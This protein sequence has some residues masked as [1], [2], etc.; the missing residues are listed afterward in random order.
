MGNLSVR[1]LDEETMRLLRLRA[2]RNGRL[3]EEE[4]RRIIREAVSTPE[5]NRRR[6]GPPV[7]A[8]SRSGSRTSG[9]CAAPT[10]PIVAMILVD[11]NVVSE[12]MRAAP[13]APW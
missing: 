11:T 5:T 6:G 7:R 12:L 9:T 8:G 1:R 2:A 10:R 4:T 13:E 3:M